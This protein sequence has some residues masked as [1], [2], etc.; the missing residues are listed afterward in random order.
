MEKIERKG[1]M[2]NNN[3]Q[4]RLCETQLKRFMQYFEQEPDTKY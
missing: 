1:I 3:I 4:Q 2:A